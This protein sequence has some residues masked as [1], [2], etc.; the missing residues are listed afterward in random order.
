MHYRAWCLRVVAMGAF[1]NSCGAA[2]SRLYKCTMGLLDGPPV[3]AVATA[4]R[5][6]CT[7]IA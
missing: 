7:S 3:S 6:N 1:W 2:P 5:G 4:M